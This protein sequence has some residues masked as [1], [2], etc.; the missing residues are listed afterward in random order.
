V[1]LSVLD[2]SPIVAG[3]SA[4]QALH[5]TVDLAILADELGYHRYWV[6]EHHGMRGVA[7]CAPAVLAGRLADATNRIRVGAGG[8]LLPNHAPLLV[9]E[10]F[11][12]LAA[13]HPGRINLGIGRA[14]GGPPQVADAI[15]RAKD[16]PAQLAELM[17]YFTG[18]QPLTAV[19]AIGNPVEFWLLGSSASS[20]RLAA[21]LDLAYAFAHHLNPQN[22]AEATL[23]Y[24]EACPEPELIVSVSAIVAE[25]DA[26]AEWLARPIRSKVARRKLG[27]R[28]LLPS[29][30]DVDSA[31]PIL[32]MLVGAPD[33]VR[34]QLQVVADETGADELMIT[35]PIHDH[36]DRRRSYELL[37]A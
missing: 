26:R 6:P 35:T 20:A 34:K 1:R 31:E 13:L 22:A 10:Q 29:P 36:A 5:N 2:T 19:P 7:S 16:F 25:T 37:T 15:Q 30:D 18:D 4:R 17:G 12:T 32:G 23:T 27:E 28:I 14:L 3:S 33:T 9:A 11:G 8:V 24:R 21:S